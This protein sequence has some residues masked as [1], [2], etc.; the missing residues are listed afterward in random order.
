MLHWIEK[1]Q[2]VILYVLAVF[3]LI[4]LTVVTIRTGFTFFRELLT[5]P[6][7][8]SDPKSIFQVLGAFLT[9]LIIVELTENILSYL[10]DHVL[11]VEVAVTTALIAVARKIIIF[12]FDEGTPENLFSL[13]AAV[14]SLALAYYLLQKIRLE[15]MGKFLK[16]DESLPSILSGR[17]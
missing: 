8:I 17:K 9:V 2:D 1:I 4:L 15:R 11:N 6:D 7:S 12:N 3:S 16:S 10:Q 13:A 5:S 14:V